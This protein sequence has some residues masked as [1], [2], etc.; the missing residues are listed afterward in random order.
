MAT[1]DYVE[2]ADTAY[3]L[4]EEFGHP[5]TFRRLDKDPADAN[6][7]WRG[8]TDPRAA[9]DATVEGLAVYV[10][11]TSAEK[12][13]ISTRVG[14]MNHS[15]DGVFIASLGS[16]ATVEL[17]KDWDEVV[18]GSRRWSIKGVETLRPDTLALLYFVKVDLV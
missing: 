7:P 8:A 4:I 5:V 2:I 6:K 12:L 14:D 3:A 1:F 16:A 13:G 17:T 10:E 15:V 18:D 9:L 11:P